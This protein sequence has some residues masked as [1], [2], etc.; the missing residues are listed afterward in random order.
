MEQKAEQYQFLQLAKKY[1]RHSCVDDECMVC[2][3][4]NY[5][6]NGQ[7]DVA[8]QFWGNQDSVMLERSSR[9]HNEV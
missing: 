1:Y 6:E 3:A 2:E 4:I 9:E 7:S 5:I 8:I